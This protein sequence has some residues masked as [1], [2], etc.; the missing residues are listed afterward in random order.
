MP[1][2]VTLLDFSREHAESYNALV[3]V[4]RLNLLLADWHD[5]DHRESLL[6]QRNTKWAKEMLRNVR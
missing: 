1:L 4:V 6:S 3:E 2:Q 5:E